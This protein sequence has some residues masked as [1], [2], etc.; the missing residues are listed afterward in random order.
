MQGNFNKKIENLGLLDQ[1]DS[2]ENSKIRLLNKLAIVTLF[3]IILLMGVR[4]FAGSNVLLPSLVSL[5]VVGFVPYLNKIGNYMLAR[6]IA[7]FGFPVSVFLIITIEG[8]KLGEFIIY[9]LCII[10]AHILYEGKTFHRNLTTLWVF[11][12]AIT[13]FLYI[14]HTFTTNPISSNI[15]GSIGL[16]ASSI[17]VVNYLIVF[18]QKE[19]ENQKHQK[20]DLLNSLKRKNI[21]LERFAYITSHD[22]KEPL[23]NII[24]FSELTS[25][26]IAA[27]EHSRSLEFLNIINSNAQQLNNLIVDTL[28]LVALENKSIPVEV[29]LNETVDQVKEL[30]A[31]TIEKRGVIV[32][33]QSKLPIVYAHPNEM[34]SCFKNIIENGIKYNEKIKPEIR[35]FYKIENETHIISISDNGNGIEQ[36]YFE[37]IFNMYGRLVSKSQYQGSGLGLAICKK[38]MENM[39]GKIWLDSDIGVGST[40]YLSIPQNN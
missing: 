34:L 32:F 8:A 31:E 3:I 40:F 13:S 1:L 23:R 24:A 10:Q 35:I 15:P 38:I 33:K 19:I 20:D 5:V 37:T 22:L 26:L 12:L 9:L 30:L 18:Y 39:N 36:D 28:E 4:Y 16:F 21:E 17:I 14:E 2:I 11:V 6:H 25:K 27:K 7:C 29:D